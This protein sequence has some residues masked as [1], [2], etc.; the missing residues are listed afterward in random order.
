[1]SSHH[2]QHFF[3][4]SFFSLF[5]ITFHLI[6]EF[7]Y[8]VSRLSIPLKFLSSVI[9]SIKQLSF[10]KFQRFLI[11]FETLYNAIENSMVNVP[12]IGAEELMFNL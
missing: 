7:F 2:F 5:V 3:M 11:L 12:D 10:K 9:V 8:S 1:M 4:F 6:L